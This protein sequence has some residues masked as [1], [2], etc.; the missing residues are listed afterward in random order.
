[1]SGGL[2]GGEGFKRFC[3]KRR[4]CVRE[5]ELNEIIQVEGRYLGRD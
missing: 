1:M 3:E 2:R 5:G 4:V